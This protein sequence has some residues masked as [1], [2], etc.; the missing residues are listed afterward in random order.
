MSVHR[1]KWDRAAADDADSNGADNATILLVEDEDTVRKLVAR[2][3]TLNGYRVLTA[4]SGQRALSLWERHHNEIDLLLTDV[5]LPE[6]PGGRELADTLQAEKPA[7]KIIY[8]S[9]YALGFAKEEECVPAETNFVHKPYR[10]E[11]LLTVVRDALQSPSK[12]SIVC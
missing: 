10:P 9:G 3:L 12:P 4:D 1:A 8:T 5:V 6:G 7:L 11:Q 2:L